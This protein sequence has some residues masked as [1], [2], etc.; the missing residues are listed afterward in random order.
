MPSWVIKALSAARKVPWGKVLA[1]I[2][3]LATKGREYW[4]RLSPEERREVLDLA[5][6]SKGKRSNLSPTQQDRIVTLLDK[7][8]R[9]GTQGTGGTAP[10]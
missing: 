8:R 4:N 10:A 1:A 6:Q 2:G 3:W 5:M 9:G 7:V